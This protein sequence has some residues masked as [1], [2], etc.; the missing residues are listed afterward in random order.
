[1]K[2][3]YGKYYVTHNGEVYNSKTGH[4]LKPYKSDNNY[5][6][7]HLIIDGKAKNKFVHRLVY[8]YF[9]GKIPEGYEINHLN[10]VRT[11]NKLE[12]LEVTNRKGNMTHAK[13]YGRTSTPKPRRPVFNEDTG[14]VFSSARKASLSMGLNPF[15][16][17][18]ALKRKA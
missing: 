9:V 16:V 3:I 13:I 2:L 4:Q 12:N 15:A 17:S 7:V 5:L 14:E 6:K 1:M 10:H 18:Q 8:E 11:D